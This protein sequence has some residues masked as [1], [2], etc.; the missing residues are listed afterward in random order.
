MVVVAAVVS[1]VGVVRADTRVFDTGLVEA[2]FSNFGSTY[3]YSE[4][5]SIY[6]DGRR[7]NII[8]QGRIELESNPGL[9][10]I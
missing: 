5:G 7:V 3:E 6:E 8:P 2:V 1:V 9:K 10:D 4:K